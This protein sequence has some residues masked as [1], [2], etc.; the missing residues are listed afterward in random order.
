MTTRV[1]AVKPETSAR[2]IAHLLLEHGISAVPVV[3]E[4]GTPI[5]MVSEGDLMPRDESE[6]EAR[7]DWWLKLL[8]E[9]EEL[10]SDFVAHVESKE[11]AARQIMSAPVITVGEA[12][13]LVEVAEALSAH[14]IKRA[15]VVRD[16]RMVG[17]ISRADI[18]KSVARPAQAPEAEPSLDRAA[19]IVFPAERVARR[20]PK[21]AAPPPAE[22]ADGLSADAFR[23]LVANFEQHETEE[24]VESHRHSIDQRRQEAREMLAAD[25]SEDAWQRMLADA[26][27]A[28]QKGEGESLLLRFPCELCTDHGRAVNAPDPNWPATLQGLAARIY[29]R[30]KKELRPRGFG[31]RA[32]VVEFPDGV[33]GHI[34]LFLAWGR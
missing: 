7:R 17:I 19:E 1:V 22:T 26:H 16:G 27:A 15:P 29:L 13:D 20:P 28:A 14:R 10:S 30:W 33:P 6:R 11:R 12:A 25:L 21:A 9:G 3:D 23:R 24:R 2:A 31:L 8:S 5:G 32:R 34:G 18:V 4:S